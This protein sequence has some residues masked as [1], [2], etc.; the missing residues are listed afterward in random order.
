MGADL[1]MYL[2]LLSVAAAR[3]AVLLAHDTI[4]EPVREALFLRWPPKDN[5]ALGMHY[6]RI[7]RDGM[8]MPIGAFDRDWKMFSE[9]LTCT[10]CLTVWTAGAL[11]ALGE[12]AG[13]GVATDVAAPIAVMGAAAWIARRM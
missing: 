11:Y 13:H 4:L 10:R 2:L 5:Q 6:Q 3:V 8:A 12:I 1:L 9:L 7:N